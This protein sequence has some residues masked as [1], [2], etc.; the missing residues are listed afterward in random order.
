MKIF[1]YLTLSLIIS[2]FAIGG[3][4]ACS[5]EIGSKEWCEDLKKKD[6][7]NWTANEAT[8]FAKHCIF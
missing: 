8:N 6:K 5:P 3:L 7:G 1:H 4:T 2:V